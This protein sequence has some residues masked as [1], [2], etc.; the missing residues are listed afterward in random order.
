MSIAVSRKQHTPTLNVLYTN[1]FFFSFFLMSMRL[2][3]CF[4]LQ[5]RKSWKKNTTIC[6]YYNLRLNYSRYGI[7]C[8]DDD[9]Q[10]ILGRALFVS[11]CWKPAAE[12]NCDW[13]PHSIEPVLWFVHSSCD[14]TFPHHNSSVLLLRPCSIG[15]RCY[16]C[17]RHLCYSIY[18]FFFFSCFFHPSLSHFYFC[19][20]HFD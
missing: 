3:I 5:G 2:Y 12:R 4:S 10:S 20:C 17:Y 9:S 19:F 14:F 16:C 15:C 11:E 6:V 18:F 7:L 1:C 13:L 8:K